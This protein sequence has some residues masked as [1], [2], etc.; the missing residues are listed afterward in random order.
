LLPPEKPSGVSSNVTEISVY[1][2]NN[3]NNN[4]N[5]TKTNTLHGGNLR[6]LNGKPGG[7]YSAH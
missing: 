7:K 1:C 4:N 3:N 5:N 2:N 6:V